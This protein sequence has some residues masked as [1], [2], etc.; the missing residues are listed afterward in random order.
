[1]NI[2][3]PE[4]MEIS[5][6]R[7]RLATVTPAEYELMKDFKAPIGLWH[8]RGFLNS[9]LHLVNDSGPL[10]HRIPRVTKD[11][12]FAPFAL[13]LAV[14]KESSEIIGS[15]GFHD[16]PDES[17]MIE[18]GLEVL[19]PF[20]RQGFALE[21]LHGMWHWAIKEHHAKTLR[22]TVS[23]NN[24]NSINLINKLGFAKIGQQ[25]DEEDGPEDI[26][27]MSVTEYEATFG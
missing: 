9:N 23:T 27:E 4:E 7:L 18:I 16:F 3:Q 5:T 25:I 19:P 21:I 12:D 1:V 6:P 2:A 11:P 26:Y 17:G 20:R 8:D 22:Y 24:T 10:A 14:L 13:R 15:S